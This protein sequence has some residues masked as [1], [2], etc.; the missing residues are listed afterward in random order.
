MTTDREAE[1]TRL[2][3]GGMKFSDI[4]A[5][6]G[7]HDRSGARK[8][9]LRVLAREERTADDI[10]GA[11]EM[12]LNDLD[13]ARDALLPDVLAGDTK[14][15]TA[16]VELAMKRARIEGVPATT[17]RQADAPAPADSTQDGAPTNAVLSLVQ[18][19]ADQDRAAG[20]G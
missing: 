2:F 10:N 18:R 13:A 9:V 5:T 20:V 7:Y 15:I 14:A 12:V 4:A 19:L 6:L 8:A 17:T 3:R 16:F 11:R 1:A